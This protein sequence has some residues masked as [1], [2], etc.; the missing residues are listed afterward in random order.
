MIWAEEPTLAS[1][2]KVTFKVP[3]SIDLGVRKKKTHWLNMNQTHTMHH[4]KYNTLKK[5]MTKIVDECNLD[6]YF[7]Y[8]NIHYGIYLPDRAQRDV[9]NVGSIVDKFVCD[10]LQYLG[11]TPDD[12][13]RHLQY[14]AYE[15]MGYCEDKKGYVEVTVTEVKKRKDV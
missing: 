7:E 3:M 13:Y 8:Y 11:F 6:F 14:V 4:A 2:S 5:M 15:Y 12:N 9:A 10:A 1:P